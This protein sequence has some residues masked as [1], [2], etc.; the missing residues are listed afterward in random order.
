MCDA[1]I[2]IIK[3][4]VN[5]SRQIKDQVL[6]FLGACDLTNKKLILPSCYDLLVL[7]NKGVGERT[8]EDYKDL[9][10]CTEST[11]AYI[12]HVTYSMFQIQDKRKRTGLNGLEPRTHQP[13]SAHLIN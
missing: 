9:D 4:S 13:T 2:A 1:D 6:L 10:A 8:R 12:L 3:T 11:E 5:I 7:R